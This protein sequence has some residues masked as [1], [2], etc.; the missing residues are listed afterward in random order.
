VSAVLFFIAAIAAITGAIGVVTLRNPFY[1]VLALAF[2]LVSLAAL[3]LLLR[4]EFVAAAQVIVYAGAVMVLY[5][6]VVAYI[7]GGESLPSGAVLRVLGP[8][9]AVALAIE[10]S[11]A[12]LGSGLQ[13]IKHKGAPFI[14]GFGTPGHIGTLLL[15]KY[16][17]PFEAASAIVPT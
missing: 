17:F 14:P 3:F 10:L 16:L 7:G 8:L 12:I 1:S 9:F 11:I 4:A 15:T 6:F 5:V 13:G 2:H